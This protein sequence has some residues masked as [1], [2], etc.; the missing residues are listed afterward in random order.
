MRG[1]EEVGA[2]VVEHG[3]PTGGRR[4][5]AE[6]KEAHGGF[7]ENGSSHADGSLDDDRLNDVGEDVAAEDAEIACAESAC[8]FDEFA[9]AGGE[10]LRSD[11]TR[12]ADPSAERKRE[13][14]VEDARTTEG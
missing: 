1:V 11:Q 6:A 2:G 10:H 9:F 14:E 5:N 4:R 12:V 13:N 8:G 7:G 3:A